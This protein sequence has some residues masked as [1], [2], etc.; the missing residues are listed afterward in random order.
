V[1]VAPLIAVAALAMP[2]PAHAAPNVTQLAPKRAVAGAVIDVRGT[3]LARTRV[4]VGGRRARVV[5]SRASSLRV[6]V[7]KVP[8][9]VRRLVVRRGG[10]SDRARLRVLRPFDG[11]VGARLDSARSAAA[12]IGAPGGELTA[13]GRDGTTYRLTVP[14]GALSGDQRIGMTPVRSFRNLP[15]TGRARGVALTP[16]GLAFA[17]P[18]TLTITTR[19]APPGKAIGFNAG[20]GFEA[21]KATRSGRTLTIAVP[22]FSSTGGAGTTPADFANAVQ[23]FLNDPNPVSESVA[24]QMQVLLGEYEELFGPGFCATQPVCGQ[25]V[26]KVRTGLEGRIDQ[27]CANADNIAL[28]PTL[29]D[30]RAVLQLEALRREFETSASADYSRDCRNRILR[31]IFAAAKAAGCDGADPLGVY[32]ATQGLSAAD[33]ASGD[34]DGDG[35]LTHLEFVFFLVEPLSTA[36]LTE[37]SDAQNCGLRRLNA[38]P[39]TAKQLCDSERD[40]AN[41]ILAKLL[42]YTR[43]LFPGEVQ[44]FIDAIDFCNVSVQVVPSGLEIFPNAFA[45]FAAIVEG[46]VDEN[47]GDVTWTA[48]RGS[49]NEGGFYSAPSSEGPDEVTGAAVVNPSRKASVPVT[50]AACKEM[51]D[52]LSRPDFSNAG[53]DFATASHTIRYGSGTIMLAGGCDG[54]EDFTVNDEIIVEVTPEGGP[55]STFSHDFSSDCSGGITAAGPFDLTSRFEPGENQVRVRYR[56]RC[57]QGGSSGNGTNLVLVG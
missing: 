34:L 43:R 57:G 26:T 40:R 38:L 46:I 17:T 42:E 49:I 41:A 19:R 13:T 22:H 7:P 11:R 3:S 20:S 51:I 12:T 5:R 25:V 23:P 33:G 15:F 44:R 10:G 16:D 39:E 28:T 32:S 54:D 4:T 2:L 53:A 48:S 8:A 31:K 24:Q 27:R 21:G 52:G 1:A 37:A 56:D 18:G 14:A 45:Q 50:V 36:A 6:V 30:F 55:T 35:E 29:A 47:N 9:G